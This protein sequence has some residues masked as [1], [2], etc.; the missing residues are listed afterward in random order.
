MGASRQAGLISRLGAFPYS[1]WFGCL[2]MGLRTGW[3][4][5]P[6]VAVWWY[7]K[8]E[9]RKPLPTVCSIYVRPISRSIK[10]DGQH[11]TCETKTIGLY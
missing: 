5:L 8:P 10:H 3:G 4:E 2:G 1:R 9:S 7:V 11:D 6:I